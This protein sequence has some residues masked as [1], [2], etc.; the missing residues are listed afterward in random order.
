M[1]KITVKLNDMNWR[2][3][4][5]ISDLIGLRRDTYLAKVLP[6]E[7]DEISRQEWVNDEA[8]ERYMRTFPTIFGSSWKQVSI[9]LPEEVADQIDAVSS[10]KKVPRDCLLDAI[11]NFVVV[12]VLPSVLVIA[13]PRKSLQYESAGTLLE[14]AIERL[15]IESLDEYSDILSSEHY[16]T[17]LHYTQE[18]IREMEA[19]F[20]SLRVNL[21]RSRRGASN[22]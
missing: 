1:R 5:E 13:A 4:S 21:R 10:N 18:S 11:V 7:V 19:A 3:I 6:A 15:P 22:E 20:D 14:R 2:L 16:R 17:E 8:G 9:M 12:R